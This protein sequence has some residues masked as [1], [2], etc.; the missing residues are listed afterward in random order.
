M[1]AVRVILAAIAIAC[2][3][4]AYFRAAAVLPLRVDLVSRAIDFSGSAWIPFAIGA[5]CA[6][7]LWSG[8]LQAAGARDRRA[9]ARRSTLIWIVTGFLLSLGPAT[10]FFRFL[11]DVFSPM[12]GIRAPARWS[13]LVFLGLAILVAFALGKRV[14][15]AAICALVLLGEQWFPNRFLHAPSRPSMTTRWLAAEKFDGAVFDVPFRTGG[16]E[17]RSMLAMATHLHPILGGVSSFEPSDLDALA[18]PDAALLRKFDT[19]YVVA[20]GGGQSIAGL[21]L[22]RRFCQDEVFAFEPMPFAEA[23]DTPRVEVIAPGGDVRA[24]LRIA[25]R[26]NAKQVKARI[27]SGALVVPLARNGDTWTATIDKRPRSVARDTDLQIEVDG[28]RLEGTFL[29]WRR[30]TELRWYDW[31]SPATWEIAQRLGAPNQ[32]G[33]DLLTSHSPANVLARATLR[34]GRGLDDAGFRDFAIGAL[35]GHRAD[36]RFTTSDRAAIVFAIIESD[37]FA[38]ANLKT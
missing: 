4:L 1:R 11:F 15:L 38:K 29:V 33:R 30:A 27:G 16:S 12:R 9:E 14:A 3:T 6:I 26:T 18:N 22:V 34:A 28:V 13:M 32:L 2:L 21:H 19:K 7:A 25:V 23:C 37:A 5:V 8:G 31:R 20:H 17:Y 24:A 35:I 36:I 10:P